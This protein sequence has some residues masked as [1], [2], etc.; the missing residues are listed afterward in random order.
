MRHHKQ[1]HP[2][3]IFITSFNIQWTPLFLL[4]F[5]VRV[6][7]EVG[8]VCKNE[9]LPGYFITLELF[10]GFSPLFFLKNEW[11]EWIREECIHCPLILR[12]RVVMQYFE[13]ELKPEG[14]R[15]L[16]KWLQVWTQVPVI[17]QSWLIS[18]APLRH[19][20]PAVSKAKVSEIW[21]IEFHEPSAKWHTQDW[22]FY[23]SWW[24]M[25]DFEIVQI[26]KACFMPPDHSVNTWWRRKHGNIL[27]SIS[28]CILYMGTER[29]G[30]EALMSTLN[31]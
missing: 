24:T 15:L 1:W 18:T 11:E 2:W 26:F 9:S 6:K 12:I 20:I 19:L 23:R 21:H 16:I 4:S 28:D 27:Q 22:Q 3:G 8:L 14:T 17:S 25:K 30:A 13:L 29:F 7:V 31:L 5:S 10:H